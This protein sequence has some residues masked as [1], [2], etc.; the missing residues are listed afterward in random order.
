MLPHNLRGVLESINVFIIV[1]PNVLSSDVQ[2][3]E[4]MEN[5]NSGIIVIVHA[6]GE[7]CCRI[8]ILQSFVVDKNHGI[9]F[10]YVVGQLW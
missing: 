9:C 10:G 7:L 6:L 8:K 4:M 2:T 1:S 3:V 5:L